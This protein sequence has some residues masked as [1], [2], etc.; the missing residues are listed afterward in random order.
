M[1]PFLLSSVR[2]VLEPD[3]RV[4]YVYF[5]NFEDARDA[6]HSKS[7]II[8]FDKP[9]IVEPVYESRSTAESS[10]SYARS[11]P[12]SITPPPH[13]YDVRYRSR[14]PIDRYY[15]DDYPPPHHHHYRD[16]PPRSRGGRGGYDRGG[17]YPAPR[18]GGYDNGGHVEGGSSKRDKFPNYLTHIPPE[19]DPMATRY[20]EK[21]MSSQFGSFSH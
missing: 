7:R 20:R 17:Y 12:R 9:A 13:H 6:R 16:Y 5:R 11:R 18:R 3:E 1:K 2:I 15:R 19:D 21:I 10:S 14:S 8:L 4:A